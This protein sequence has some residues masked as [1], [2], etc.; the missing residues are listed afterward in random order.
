MAQ[1]CKKGKIHGRVNHMGTH[2]SR[3]T[4]SQPNCGQ[5][6]MRGYLRQCLPQSFYCSC[7]FRLVGCDVSGL[8]L[9]CLA[10]YMALYD[11]G[12][13]AINYSRGHTH[14]Q[15]GGRWPTFKKPCQNFHLRLPLWGGDEKIGSIVGKDA[16]AGRRLKAQFLKDPCAGKAS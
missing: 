15:H 3:C 16:K 6:P 4:H 13:Y 10:H 14:H 11:G 8:E 9:R 2:T 5:I 12:E 7:G 1:A